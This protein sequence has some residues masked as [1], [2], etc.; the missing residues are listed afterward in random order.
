ME[1]CLDS[2][3]PYALELNLA[4]V[5]LDCTFLGQGVSVERVRG[6]RDIMPAQ[7]ARVYAKRANVHTKQASMYACVYASKLVVALESAEV[8]E[9][10]SLEGLGPVD[11]V[12]QV[13]VADVV[14]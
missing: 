14:A 7:L 5:S 2:R 11:Q 10:V 3:V 4:S 12:R 9:S 6:D 1:V 13:K 8:G